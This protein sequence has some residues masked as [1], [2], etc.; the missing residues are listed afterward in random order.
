MARWAG[1]LF[2]LVWAAAAQDSTRTLTLGGAGVTAGTGIGTEASPS[3]LET[4]TGPTEKIS[5]T[6]APEEEASSWLSRLGGS[7][8][9]LVVISISTM[10]ACIFTAYKRMQAN[11]DSFDFFHPFGQKADEGSESESDA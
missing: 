11:G 9:A 2:M 8:I 1:L 4:V 3:K 10:P 6:T 7:G 5:A